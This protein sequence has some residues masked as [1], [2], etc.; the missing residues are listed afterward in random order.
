MS[1]EKGQLSPEHNTHTHTLT[2]IDTNIW[3]NWI[4]K[5]LIDIYM[6]IFTKFLINNTDNQDFG[7]NEMQVIHRFCEVKVCIVY[8]S[9]F[10]IK[11]SM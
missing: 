8:V 7:K 11:F 6:L 1:E 5:L 10:R 9:N 4:I 2:Y 3:E